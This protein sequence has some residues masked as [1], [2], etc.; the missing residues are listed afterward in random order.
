MH[1]SWV[2]YES[3]MHVRGRRLVLVCPQTEWEEMLPAIR[4]NYT[5]LREGISNEGDAERLARE[6]GVPK[7]AA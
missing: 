4:A 2:I 7:R 3:L 1:H 6:L 5:L